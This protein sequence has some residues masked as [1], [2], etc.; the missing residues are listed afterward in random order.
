[1]LNFELATNETIPSI[2][3]MMEQFYAIDQYPFDEEK[4]KKNLHL[5]IN[6]PELGRLW[7]IKMEKQLVGYV[8]LAYCFSFEYGGRDAFIDELF[9]KTEFRNQGIGQQT[10]DFLENASMKLGVNSIHLE[11][12]KHNEA[13]KKLYFKK[14]YSDTGRHL[15]TKAVVV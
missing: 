8:C 1:M 9:I 13:G 4:N 2:L 11:V 15:L 14:G 7:L 3:E 12:E 5:F 10:M 6:N